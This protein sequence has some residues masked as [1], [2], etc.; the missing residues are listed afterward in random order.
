MLVAPVTFFSILSG[1]S[2]M[3]DA[4]DAGRIGS[5]LALV[6]VSMMLVMSF[7]SM[8]SGIFCFSEDLSFNAYEY[9]GR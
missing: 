8:I 3:S 6:T 5:R 7:L 9:G 1:L 2:Q 4:N